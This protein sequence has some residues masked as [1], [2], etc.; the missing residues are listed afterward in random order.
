[1]D[2][3]SETTAELN[4]LARSLDLLTDEDV[5]RLAR[6]KPSTTEAWRKRGT[7]PGYVL[8][9]NAYYYPRKAVADYIASGL[10]VHPNTARAML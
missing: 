8:F 3:C 1:M 2:P 9:G 4:G 5:Q 6:V 10:R 7:G